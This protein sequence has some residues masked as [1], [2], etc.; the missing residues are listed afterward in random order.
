MVGLVNEPKAEFGLTCLENTRQNR[1]FDNSVLVAE[2]PKIYAKVG[3]WCD[4]AGESFFFFA[5]GVLVQDCLKRRDLS[6]RSVL[7]CVL[8]CVVM[9][10]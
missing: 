2:P 6:E 1:T 8:V 4:V 5:C 7:F 9:R 10:C 3:G